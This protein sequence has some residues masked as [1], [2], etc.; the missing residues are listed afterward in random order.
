MFTGSGV[1]SQIMLDKLALVSQVGQ[2]NNELKQ[3]RLAVIRL[4]TNQ[5]I[6]K[7]TLSEVA[8]SISSLEA[9]LATKEIQLKYYRNLVGDIQQSEKPF[10]RNI[11]LFDAGK[12]EVGYRIIVQ[13][14]AVDKGKSSEIKMQVAIEGSGE[15]GE[16]SFP[17]TDMDPTFPSDE[18]AFKIKYFK[19]FEGRI[20]LPEAF[21]P[22][23]IVT[24]TW[25]KGHKE[26]STEKRFNWDIQNP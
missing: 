2:L 24:R 11:E 14:G 8:K 12:G 4:E 17:L 25:I 5:Q 21:E 3:N 9:E 26:D 16:I 19:R 10:V 20:L 23:G 15:E 6:D 22:E 1:F 7:Q 13:Q 18:D